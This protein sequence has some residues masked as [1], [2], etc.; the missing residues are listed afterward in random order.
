MG[1]CTV[2]E[3]FALVRRTD[4]PCAMCNCPYYL[5]CVIAHNLEFIPVRS[6]VVPGVAYSAV[7]PFHFPLLSPPFGDAVLVN[8][9]AE[10]DYI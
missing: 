8:E 1:K 10:S 6:D 9:T 4:I 3:R 2:V 7:M 5:I